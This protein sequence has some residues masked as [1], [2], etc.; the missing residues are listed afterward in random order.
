M[1]YA[2]LN[3]D[4]RMSP[5]IKT[6]IA[7]SIVCLLVV[8]FAVTYSLL[9]REIPIA[10]ATEE[11]PAP[12]PTPRIV[13]KAKLSPIE[14]ATPTPEPAPTANEDSPRASYESFSTPS[15]TW[16]RKGNV[17]IVLNTLDRK[18]SVI[19]LPEGTRVRFQ[20][21]ADSGIA[22]GVASADAANPKGF[23]PST[24]VCSTDKVFKTQ[25]E[26]AIP[27]NALLLIADDRRAFTAA[28]ALFSRGRNADKVVAQ[29][30][31]SITMYQYECV[32]GC[33]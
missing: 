25:V 7:V 30:K 17:G 29:N 13:A 15:Y 26:C 33:P 32:T 1:I 22:F 27:S 16:V 12:A 10:Q 28:S 9:H 20:I 21:V 4:E 3:E 24:L 19:N 5:W 2:P 6:L 31:V 14:D 23:D 8:T 11:K 18:S